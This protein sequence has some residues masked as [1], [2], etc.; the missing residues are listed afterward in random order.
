MAAFATAATPLMAQGLV[1]ASDSS[2][3]EAMNAVARD[4]EAGHQG[5]RVKVQGGAAGALLE[6]IGRGMTADVLA[7]A[8]AVTVELGEQRRLLRSDARNAFA[9]NA[10]VLVVPASLAVPVQRLSDLAQPEVT[11]IAMARPTSVPAGRYAREAINAQRLWSS[12]QRKVVI[13]EDARAVLD[14]VA[15]SDAQAGFVYAS[16]VAAVAARVRVVE[17]LATASPIRHL[18]TVTAGSQSPAL[19]SE[20]VAYLR[21]EPARSVFKRYGFGLP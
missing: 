18:A 3:I 2:C 12:L 21:S 7:G 19:A 11:R 10:L 20:F 15:R 13:A 16:D 8:D 1:V 17:T 14:L 6:Q 9:T 5:L 4:F